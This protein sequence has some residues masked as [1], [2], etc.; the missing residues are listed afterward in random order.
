MA[1]LLRFQQMFQANARHISAMNQLIQILS[2][3]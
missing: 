2:S 1:N 3:L